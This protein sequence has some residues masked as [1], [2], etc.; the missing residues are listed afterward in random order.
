MP[1]HEPSRYLWDF[2]NRP[3]TGLALLFTSALVFLFPQ[4]APLTLRIV[5]GI[6]LVYLSIR[7]AEEATSWA[8]TR[9]L[10][11]RQLLERGENF[12]TLVVALPPKEA[13]AMLSSSLTPPFYKAR[14]YRERT[15]FYFEAYGLI[16]LQLL[17]LLFYG[18]AFV[19]ILGLLLA[20][21]T[22]KATQSFMVPGEELSLE[23][24]DVSFR[25][26]EVYPEG[27]EGQGTI[28][29]GGKPV[30]SGRLAPGRPLWASFNVA[31]PVGQGPA[32]KLK[33]SSQERFILYPG[34]K[35]YSG[36]LAIPFLMPNE[37]R[38]VF[39]PDHRLI[40]RFILNPKSDNVFLLEVFKEG[41]ERPELSLE[42]AKSEA[43]ELGGV[44]VEI[45]TIAS[46]Q[47]RLV[48]VISL[49]PAMLGF[50]LMAIAL[51]LWL[52]LPVGRLFGFIQAE[53]KVKVHW[54]QEEPFKL[55]PFAGK[56]EWE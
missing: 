5:G 31:L 56:G 37:E 32:L 28:L 16:P 26:D 49:W 35:E 40:L 10:S 20:P 39:L 18:G 29:S 15:R 13:A 11:P 38:Y 48:R 45:I 42:V 21:L 24:T 46:V 54:A 14:V 25:L 6:W 9:G 43:L 27:L 3:S 44:K 8:K 36:E 52:T 2:L 12:R 4:F 1:L 51:L 30:R 19:A 22:D 23:G 53:A 50:L 47:L 17:K 55:P 41:A 33:A 34:G 7:M